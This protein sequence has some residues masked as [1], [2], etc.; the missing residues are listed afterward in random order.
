MR[1]TAAQIPLTWI[2]SSSIRFVER[3]SQQSRTEDKSQIDWKNRSLCCT[4]TIEKGKISINW[5]LCDRNAWA[6]LAKSRE[7]CVPGKSSLHLF[8]PFWP[9]PCPSIICRDLLYAVHSEQLEQLSTAQ[10]KAGE[11]DSRPA[12]WNGL[13]AQILNVLLQKDKEKKKK[14]LILRKITEC[15]DI[16]TL[17]TPNYPRD[18]LWCCAAPKRSARDY[19]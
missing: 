9:S 19:R 12:H 2:S 11:N 10:N 15:T 17:I 13:G 18:R 1:N 6:M 16:G 5:G 8:D 4:K 3:P 14:L 7:K